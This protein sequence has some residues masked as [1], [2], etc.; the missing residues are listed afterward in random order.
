VKK[1]F[2]QKI[3][4]LVHLFP[5]LM[6]YLITGHAVIK[7]KIEKKDAVKKN[8]SEGFVGLPRPSGLMRLPTIS[9]GREEFRSKAHIYVLLYLL[10]HLLSF[11]HF[12]AKG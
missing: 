7:K 6:E 10:K 12:K 8:S 3:I 4:I 11:R 5:V 1:Y 2:I 9:E